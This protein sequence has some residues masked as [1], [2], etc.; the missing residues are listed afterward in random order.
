MERPVEVGRIVR[1]HGIRG[2]V[3]VRRYGETPGV[4]E[5]GSSLQVGPSGTTLR[6]RAARPHQ[7]FWIVSFEGVTDRTTAETLAGAAL[8]VEADRLPPL[9]EDAYYNFQLIGMRV[10][11]VG[12]E[13]LGILEEIVETGAQD[14]YVVR[15]KGREILLPALREVIRTVDVAAGAMTVEPLPGLLDEEPAPGKREDG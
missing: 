1:P 6:V 12:G 3:I 13:D 9:P 8:K 11:T 14:V 2:E 5:Q 4:L 15:G 7:Q 10:R